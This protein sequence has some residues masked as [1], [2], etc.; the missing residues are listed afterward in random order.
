MM[1]TRVAAIFAIVAIGLAMS[2]AAGTDES[3]RAE[4]VRLEKETGLAITFYENELGVVSFK[5]HAAYQMGKL[6]PM[7]G[8]GGTVSPDGAEVAVDSSNWG[9]GYRDHTMFLD[10][11]GTDGRGLREYPEVRGALPCWSHDGSKLAMTLLKS[12]EVR[13]GILD[14]ASKKM[15]TFDPRTTD[16]YS[17]FT[18]QCWSPDDKELVFE[19]DGKVQVYEIEKDQIR[20]LAT[21]TNP[22]WSPDGSW[23]AY[24]DRNDYYVI[25]PSGNGKKKLFHKRRAVS[26]LFWS[27]DGRFVAYVHE[28]FLALDVEFYHLMVRRLADGDEDW[29]ADGIACCIEYQW[30]E[31]PELLKRALA[32]G[33]R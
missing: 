32:E 18:S 15:R 9:P 24:R 12:P 33:K 17:R 14:L 30:V 2:A 16:E 25:H 6:V 1:L 4:L 29:V 13:L 21:G 19:A 20:N 27:P 26:G 10:I 8:M 11:V 28:D 3:V 23:I 7:G 5:K 31:N 22:T